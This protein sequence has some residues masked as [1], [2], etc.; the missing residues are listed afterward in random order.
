[1]ETDA[2]GLQNIQ[3]AFNH[4]LLR[5][6]SRLGVGEKGDG[7]ALERIETL[8]ILYLL[9]ERE[10]EIG[11]EGAPPARGYS[12]RSLLADL[13]DFD[14]QGGSTA[15]SALDQLIAGGLVAENGEQG[16]NLT[17]RAAEMVAS[18]DAAFPGMPGLSFVAY[19]LQTI[20][21]VSSDRKTLTEALEQVERTLLVQGRPLGQ[22]PNRT[23]LGRQG[24]NG[25]PAKNRARTTGRLEQLYRLRQAAVGPTSHPKIVTRSGC[26]AQVEVKTLF[27]RKNSELPDE[28]SVTAEPGIQTP[29][30]PKIEGAAKQVELHP[31]GGSLTPED[32][33]PG[34]LP[35]G[36]EGE[37][38]LPRQGG[39]W[40]LEGTDLAADDTTAAVG[41]PPRGEAAEPD[42]NRTT[43]EGATNVPQA[44][45]SGPTGRPTGA[46]VSAVGEQTVG[47]A[48]LETKRAAAGQ[49]GAEGAPES[50]PPASDAAEIVGKLHPQS[51]AIEKDQTLHCPIC[52]SGSVQP[53]VTPKG[54]TYYACSRAGCNFI[55]WGRPY[56]YPCPVCGNPFLVE[57]PIRGQGVGL[58]CPRAT[59]TFR[60]AHLNA[61]SFQT[62]PSRQQPN[63]AI[64]AASGF[65]KVVRKVVRARRPV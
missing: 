6:L 18:Y 39:S 46:E 16:I 33:G 65:R 53:A 38:R 40:G 41:D 62:S 42:K 57:A 27:P 36:G 55:S 13:A 5:H 32:S 26:R 31:G 35:T 48:A 59:C 15:S 44:G 8:T 64:P 21:E 45:I 3:T 43:T 54:K 58:K 11:P 56:P 28:K 14:P 9:H 49:R 7:P 30:M 1:V 24:E 61:P 20:Q 29:E 25:G 17:A 47:E 10:N 23:I 60:Q 34:D 52:R 2:A 22:R 19:L 37:G 4:V 51:T 12:R 50:N 63:R